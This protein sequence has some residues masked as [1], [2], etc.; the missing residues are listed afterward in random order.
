MRILEVL[1]LGWSKK[2]NFQRKL[3]LIKNFN[4]KNKSLSNKYKFIINT[5]FL[6][7]EKKQGNKRFAKINLNKFKDV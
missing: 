6:S 3:K 2:V 7:I 5:G 1:K 4:K